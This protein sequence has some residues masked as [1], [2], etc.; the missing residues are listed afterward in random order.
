MTVRNVNLC[1][2][3]SNRHLYAHLRLL[4]KVV[5]CL[6][7]QIVFSAAQLLVSITYISDYFISAQMFLPVHKSLSLKPTVMHMTIL[8]LHHIIVYVH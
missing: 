8:L 2:N 7:T 1:S 4:I 3:I 5:Q 6:V